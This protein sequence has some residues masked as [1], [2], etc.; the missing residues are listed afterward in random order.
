MIRVA[1]TVRKPYFQE[2]A[3]GRKRVE[4]RRASP[5]WL[6]FHDKVEAAVAR[7]ERVEATFLCGPRWHRRVVV[8]VEK[9][10]DAASGLGRP[11]SEQGRKD[12]GDGPVIAFRLGEAVKS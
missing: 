12:V 11:L 1:F 2:I 5:Y 10:V 4:I 7:G 6:R 8:D 9:W 3:A